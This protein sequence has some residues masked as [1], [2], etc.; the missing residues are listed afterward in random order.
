MSLGTRLTQSLVNPLWKLV[1]IPTPEVF[2]GPGCLAELGKL[3]VS[4]GL[5]KVLVVTDNVLPSLG[6]LESTYESLRNNNVEF[7]IF[8]KVT[9]DPDIKVCVTGCK[10]YLE[11]KCEAIVAFGGGSSMD[12]AKYIAVLSTDPGCDPYKYLG[13]FQLSPFKSLPN[14]FAIPTT[15][16]TGSEA[17]IAA[18]ISDKDA[19]KKYAVMD[20]RLCAPYAFLDAT[21]LTNLPKPITAATGV[22]AL[23]HAIES[24]MAPFRTQH[25]MDLSLRAIKNIFDFLPRCYTNGKDLEARNKLLI[26]SFDAGVAFTRAGV[27]YVHAIAHQLGALFHTPHGVANAMLLAHVLDFYNDG[28]TDNT[29]TSLAKM[30]LVVENRGHESVKKEEKLELATRF[31]SHVRELCASLDIPNFAEGLS[32]KYVDEIVDRALKEAHGQSFDMSKEP[33]KAMLDVGYPVPKY[34][35]ADECRNIVLKILDP[36]SKA[37]L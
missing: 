11:E 21:L 2:T 36:K 25:T 35:T 8:D 15:A 27:G 30:C 18:V 6:L 4:K 37:S 20:F 22:D 17:T 28:Y 14:I 12:C 31:I 26:A 23:T 1:P 19:Q 7:V 29:L 5:K 16:G 13:P 9:P 32:A 10:L 33:L 3:C 34:M 24:Y